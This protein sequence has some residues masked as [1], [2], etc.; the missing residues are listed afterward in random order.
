MQQGLLLSQRNLRRHLPHLPRLAQGVQ[1]GALHQV[2]HL[3]PGLPEPR[4]LRRAPD[5]HHHGHL[6]PPHRLVHELRA[7]PG[8]HGLHHGRGHHHSAG[9]AQGHLRVQGV[10]GQPPA[11]PQRPRVALRTDAEDH[12]H[13]EHPRHALPLLHQEARA[14]QDL[15]VGAGQGPRVGAAGRAAAV[16]LRPGRALHGGVGHLPAQGQ[17]RGRGRGGARGA[18]APARAQELRRQHRQDYQHSHHHHH[19]GVPRVHRG[20]DQV[21]PHVPLPDQPHAGVHR[22]GLRQHPGRLHAL[23]PRRGQLLAVLHQRGLRVQVGAVQPHRG[24]RHHDLPAGAHALPLPHAQVRAG[25]DSGGGGAGA[26]GVARVPLPLA[27]QQV[28]VPRHAHV[29]HHHRL[30]QHGVRHLR[31]GGPVRVPGA[32]QRHQAQGDNAGG[33]PHVH[34][35]ARVGDD[36]AHDGASAGD[37]GQGQGARR[38]R[39][40]LLPRG[41]QPHVRLRGPAQ[42]VHLHARVGQQQDQ[43]D[44]ALYLPHPGH[45]GDRLDGAQGHDGRDGRRGG[46]G[47]PVLHPGAAPE[48]RQADEVPPRQ[49]RLQDDLVLREHEGAGRE[50][51]AQRGLARGVQRGGH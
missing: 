45:D 30:L 4:E 25:V 46:A 36:Y 9:A 20:G 28:R 8:H 5:G 38:Q 12:A 1:D 48:P 47:H 19:R 13:H 14:G 17:G 51:V 43:Q 37:G 40:L 41:G 21:R 49:D 44:Q 22:A 6:R 29:L 10:Q 39:H 50:R 33:A 16:G 23:L 35:P 34:L 11:G 31:V 42:E 26:G 3:E 2:L 15:L 7:Q 32:L 18:A 24:H 27:H